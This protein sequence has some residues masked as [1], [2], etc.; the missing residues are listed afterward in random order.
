MKKFSLKIEDNSRVM[1]EMHR[2]MVRDELEKLFKLFS[3]AT[4]PTIFTK[5]IAEVCRFLDEMKKK[6]EGELV[7]L[8]HGKSRQ[9]HKPAVKSILAATVADVDAVLNEGATK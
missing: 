6:E 2:L 4:P 8:Y 3:S 5:L 1:V 9:F 7:G